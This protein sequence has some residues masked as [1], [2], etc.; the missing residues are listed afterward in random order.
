MK[1]LLLSCFFLV[2]VFFTEKTEAQTFTIPSDTVEM[3]VA[4]SAKLHNDITNISDTAI[5]VIWQV[6]DHTM[7]ADWGT[8]LGICDNISCYS[9]G[10]NRLLNGERNTTYTIEPGETA[11]FYVMPELTDAAPGTHYIKIKMTNGDYSKDS[12]YV[13]HK[14]TTG[15]ATVSQSD[16]NIVAYPNPAT[17]E[18]TV[19][20]D[21]GMD[22]KRIDLYGLNGQ[23]V[24]GYEV[25]GSK[26]KIDVS[27]VVPGL[28]VIQLID[29][30]GQIAGSRQIV[31]Q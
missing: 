12:W 28:Y 17:N 16:V 22:V 31:R 27:G 11:N 10:N 19:Q 18:L 2:I 3:A 14:Y 20:H 9:N 4:G 26:S 6:V 30:K 8:N 21:G 15:V 29:K 23:R 25:S 13:I 5:S 24:A 7:P 1:K